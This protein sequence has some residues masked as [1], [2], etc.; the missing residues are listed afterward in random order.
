MATDQQA[1][2]VAVIGG[3]PGGYPAAFAAARGGHQVTLIDE[4]PALGGVCLRCGCIP[5][6]T[7]LH[8]ADI[9]AAA[10]GAKQF[11]IEFGEPRISVDGL[12]G[13]KDKVIDRMSG[14]IAMLARQQK[15]NVVCGRARFDG[16]GRLAV[17]GPD[18]QLV[19]FDRA[20]IATGSSPLQLPMFPDDPRVL[21]STSALDISGP[22]KNLL[23]VGGGYIGL[24][25]GS[26]YA[27]LGTSVSVVEMTAGLL[28]GADRDLVRPLQ[29]RL[30]D[31]FENIW[32]RTRV[33]RAG[34][35]PGGI[36][37]EF[38]GE[39]ADVAPAWFDQVLVAVGRK[40]N[41]ADLGLDSVDVS[42]DKRGFVRVDGQQRTSNASI[43]AVGDVVGGSMLAH[44]ATA[45]ARV[46]I[47]AMNGEPAQF[48]HV[49][50]PAVVFTDP[51]IAWCGLTETQARAEGR[52]IRIVRFP[53]AALGRAT[54]MGRNE[55]MSKL[56]IDP[57][58]ER[59]LGAGVV[60]VG[61]GELIA[62]QV[63]AME[64]GAVASEV[65][66]A[67]HPHPTTSESVMEA[68]EIFYGASPHYLGRVAK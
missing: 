58:D 65:A 9:M 13:W 25:L 5:S 56:I 15:V 46:A 2:R 44:K 35:F 37:C 47:E 48:D 17:E 6:K 1:L 38:R 21:D 42:T 63:I 32:L 43:F 49:A 4:N 12:L 61:A 40:P 30:K 60:G 67:I 18:S 54:A 64:M 31:E 62:A 26:V 29:R 52:E 20:V 36:R 57:V 28:P 59:V 24:E 23:V 27:A 34:A 51:E 53:W 19:E 55:G 11:G 10:E 68:A 45:E 22:P 16:P 39:D 14:G 66:H 7:L 33:E 8:A 50:I 3:G 41:S